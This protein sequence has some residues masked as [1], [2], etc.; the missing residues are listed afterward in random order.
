MYLI[1]DKWE[2]GDMYFYSYHGATAIYN[3]TNS[4]G[5]SSLYF[6]SAVSILLFGIFIIYKYICGWFVIIVIVIVMDDK[7]VYYV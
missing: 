3:S 6:I 4:S 2:D 5:N 1:N 7:I